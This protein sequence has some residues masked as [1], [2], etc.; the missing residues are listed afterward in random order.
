M[1]TITNTRAGKESV[2]HSFCAVQGTKDSIAKVA[3]P[4][5][6]VCAQRTRFV[7]R[8]DSGVIIGFD[9]ESTIPNEFVAKAHGFFGTFN[10]VLFDKIDR[11]QIIPRDDQ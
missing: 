10:L 8:N 1:A 3:I 5:D 9:A 11:L 6:I 4:S 2:L 7:V